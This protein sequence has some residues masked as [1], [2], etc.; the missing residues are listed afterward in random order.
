MPAQ[1][2]K[3]FNVTKDMFGQGNITLDSGNFRL[4]LIKSNTVAL[5][6]GISALTWGSLVTDGVSSIPT[7]GNYAA[8]GITMATVTWSLN[9]NIMRFDAVD[10]SLSANGVDHLSIVAALI[11]TSLN[12]RPLCYASLSTSAINLSAGN[13]LIIQ[14]DASGIFTLT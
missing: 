9:G 14:F 11:K 12:D 5:S 8:S 1:A 4:I 3:V 6:Q 7:A 2:F 13:K 10:V